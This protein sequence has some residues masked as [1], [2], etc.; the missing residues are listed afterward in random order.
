MTA[1]SV[2]GIGPGD[3][4]K[5]VAY[6]SRD[7]P[8]LNVTETT[9]NPQDLITTVVEGGGSCC[10]CTEWEIAFVRAVAAFSPTDGPLDTG[11]AYDPAYEWF[12]FM[13][14]VPQAPAG[15][16]SMLSL[17]PITDPILIMVANISFTANRLVIWSPDGGSTEFTES[18]NDPNT[19]IAHIDFCAMIPF[20]RLLQ[21][22]SESNDSEIEIDDGSNAPAGNF[23]TRYVSSS[24]DIYFVLLRRPM[25][26]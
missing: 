5:R 17:T 14:L 24:N 26:A 16:P 25:N 15:A 4:H 19:P 18:V 2:T 7:L 20:D 9:T 13:H 21:I 1:Q 23:T 22:V 10:T 12:V 6:L 8:K 11:V 3:A